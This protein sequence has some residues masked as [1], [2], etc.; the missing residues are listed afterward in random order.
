MIQKQK[1]ITIT[2]QSE[3]GTI[4]LGQAIGKNAKP[5]TAVMLAGDLGAGKTV[6]AK[7]IAKGLGYADW[8]KIKSPT[9]TIVH[10]IDSPIPLFHF[11]VYRLGVVEELFEIGFEEYLERDGVVVVEWGDK[12]NDYLPPDYLC[13]TLFHAGENTRKIM[14]RGPHDLVVRLQKKI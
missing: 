10:E 7:G 5:C 11:D 1:E 8:K 13:V 14:V 6:C 3:K 2:T 9:F 12:F 4:R